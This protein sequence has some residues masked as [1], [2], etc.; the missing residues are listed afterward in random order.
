[1]YKSCDALVHAHLEAGGQG[2]FALGVGGTVMQ[3][4]WPDPETL[5]DF[6]FLFRFW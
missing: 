1:M 6:P 2:L 4:R 3:K 5:N